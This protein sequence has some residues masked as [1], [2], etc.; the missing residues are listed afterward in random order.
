VRRDLITHTR[1]G[2]HRAV[3]GTSRL[4]DTDCHRTVAN[5]ALSSG[6]C[7]VYVRYVTETDQDAT[8]ATALQLVDAVV[9]AH[10]RGG[11]DPVA[12]VEAS[13]ASEL[14]HAGLLLLAGSLL[15][16]IGDLGEAM[17]PGQ[18]RHYLSTA[19][20]ELQRS[21]L[22]VASI[23]DGRSH[24]SPIRGRHTMISEAGAA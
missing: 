22:A 4:L 14:D 17:L 20:Q 8:M 11:P 19:R 18:I 21:D 5:H 2:R 10:E 7:Y 16:V 3:I 12:L 13:A 1:L 23:E 24:P 9:S 15:A 6:A